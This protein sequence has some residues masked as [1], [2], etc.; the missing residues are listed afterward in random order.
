MQLLGKC[1]TLEN[2]IVSV[3]GINSDSHVFGSSFETELGI[4][5]VRGIQGDLMFHVDVVGSC[6][7]EHSGTTEARA[8][9]FPPSSVQKATTHSGFQLVTEYGLSWLQLTQFECANARRILSGGGCAIWSSD[10]TAIATSFTLG[11]V[12]WRGVRKSESL[13]VE[14]TS[15]SQRADERKGWMSKLVMPFELNL[16]PGRKVS[17]GAVKQ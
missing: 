13:L 4:Y 5:S 17:V 10:L 1:F 11:T 8:G 9:G 6:V 14:V 3:V 12:I 7:T 16:G 15:S 2:A